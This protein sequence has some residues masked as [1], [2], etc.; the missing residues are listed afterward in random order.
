MT[1]LTDHQS[2][3]G[4]WLGVLFSQCYSLMFCCYSVTQYHY[5]TRLKSSPRKNTVAYFVSDE[6]KMFYGQE[7]SWLLRFSFWLENWR[8]FK[9]E[10]EFDFFLEAGTFCFRSRGRWRRRWRQAKSETVQVEG[11]SSCFVLLTILL[12]PFFLGIVL[13]QNRIVF[14]PG[15]LYQPGKGFCKV[16]H[17]RNGKYFIVHKKFY[18]ILGVLV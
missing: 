8:N 9:T 4:R 5:H 16:H 10:A 13:Q 15:N 12:N 6:V 7:T 18:W 17:I 14:V 11:K 1:W 2:E 3:D